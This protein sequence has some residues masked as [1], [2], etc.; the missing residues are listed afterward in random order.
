VIEV[1]ARVAA[2][3]EIEFDELCRS[4]NQ[5]FYRLFPK[6]AAS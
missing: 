3:L 1:A 5:N 6:A 4:T 2:E